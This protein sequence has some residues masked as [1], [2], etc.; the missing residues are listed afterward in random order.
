MNQTRRN[1]SFCTSSVGSL[2]KT[3]GQPIIDQYVIRAFGIFAP[4]DDKKK[5]SVFKSG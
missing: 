4:N 5:L 3:P 2:T 1:Q